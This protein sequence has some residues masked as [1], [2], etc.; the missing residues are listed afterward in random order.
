MAVLNPSNYS[1]LFVWSQ[2]PLVFH[3]ILDDDLIRKFDRL[4]TMP[5]DT[6]EDKIAYQANNSSYNKD[7]KKLMAEL[8]AFFPKMCKQWGVLIDTVLTYTHNNNHAV[9]KWW[10]AHKDI[11]WRNERIF[12]Q[13][14]FA[15]D[16]NAEE[17][18]GHDEIKELEDDI[19][20]PWR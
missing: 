10:R 12:G 9:R 15:D 8:K 4:I 18:W 13:P 17:I 6:T 1:D 14:I 7:K 3:L 11:A 19:A 16:D 5:T 20:N 2:Y